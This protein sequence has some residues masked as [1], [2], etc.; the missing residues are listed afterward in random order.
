MKALPTSQPARIEE[1]KKHIQ[2][3]LSNFRQIEHAILLDPD[4]DGSHLPT[5]HNV[6]T[7][8]QQII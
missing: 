5:W 7:A 1:I 3:A 4:S 8:F 6:L 2:T